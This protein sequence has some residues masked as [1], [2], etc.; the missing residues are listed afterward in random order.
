[1]ANVPLGI[2]TSV[3]GVS[4]VVGDLKK[5]E[6]QSAAITRTT[7]G[8]GL[9]FQKTARSI[10]A[11]VGDARSAFAAFGTQASGSVGQVIASGQ[12]LAGVFSSG[13]PVVGAVAVVA[14]AIIQMVKKTENDMEAL[15]QKS[16]DLA[17]EEKER[18][19]RTLAFAGI[20]TDPVKRARLQAERFIAQ[21]N[22]KGLE[23]LIADEQRVFESRK[24]YLDEMVQIRADTTAINKEQEF[25]FSKRAEVDAMVQVLKDAEAK[26]AEA[27]R[28]QLEEMRKMTERTSQREIVFL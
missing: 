10:K 16:R 21:N 27:E 13:G 23:N 12:M 26:R 19:R 11:G 17:N 7:A 22:F 28:R 3:S 14:M 18:S 6:A 25:T 8:Q 15:V 24:A 20:E 5:I 2:E 4:A 9:E 1:M